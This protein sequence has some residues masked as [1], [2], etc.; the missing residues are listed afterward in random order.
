[1]AIKFTSL[2]NNA[3]S[4]T[5]TMIY[6]NNSQIIEDEN[7]RWR[8]FFPVFSRINNRTLHLLQATK[9]ESKYELDQKF[10][11]LTHN[12]I[13]FSDG[14]FKEKCL[15]M[16]KNPNHQLKWRGIRDLDLFGWVSASQNFCEKQFKFCAL[17]SQNLREIVNVSDR[18][19]WRS[20]LF[21]TFDL[22]HFLIYSSIVWNLFLLIPPVLLFT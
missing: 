21:S 6:F 1:M 4:V 22:R 5:Q 15:H 7:K 8:A 16:T 10:P 18:C 13:V 3:N 19:V 11:L 14:S 9:H 17:N 12:F 20:R 2:K